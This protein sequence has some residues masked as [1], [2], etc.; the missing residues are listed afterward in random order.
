MGLETII[1]EVC[2]YVNRTREDLTVNGVDL[3]VSAANAGK[4]WAQRNVDFELLR[5]SVR[6]T[7]PA[8]LSVNV[9]NGVYHPTY[10]S[11]G[12]NETVRINRIERAF[13]LPEEGA[14]Y[15]VQ[16]SRLYPIDYRLRS[17]IA[18]R[19]QRLYEARVAQAILNNEDLPEVTTSFK[20]LVRQGDQ[21]YLWPKQTTDTVVVL[22][23]VTWADE[24][25]VSTHEFVVGNLTEGQ[26]PMSEIRDY[27][28]QPRGTFDGN[29]LFV[30]ERTEDIRA[31]CYY[32]TESE[33]WR[34]ANY[35]DAETAYWKLDAQG[36]AAINGGFTWTAVGFTATAD[37]SPTTT[38]ATAQTGDDDFFTDECGDWLLLYILKRMTVFLKQDERFAVTQKQV[39]EAWSAVLAWNN[40]IADSASAQN[41]DLD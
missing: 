23:V 40:S 35:L 30:T 8:G 41:Y 38:F 22:D 39:D 26:G 14:G 9:G 7:V 34:I 36:V 32:D 37:Q 29:T 31:V 24:Y 18:A 25:V 20:V 21:V 4:R 28:F 3:V 19:E 2:A 6:I 16:S 15:E 1:A 33:T 13:I 5:K 10:S 11:P 27:V 17:E 12:D